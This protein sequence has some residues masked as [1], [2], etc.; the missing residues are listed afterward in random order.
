MIVKLQPSNTERLTFNEVV[1]KLIEIS[2]HPF[3]DA[4]DKVVIISVIVKLFL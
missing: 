2:T 1:K 3:L 4:S